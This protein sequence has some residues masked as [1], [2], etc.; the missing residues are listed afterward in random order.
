M[1]ENDAWNRAFISIEE[2]STWQSQL[3]AKIT[4]K[5]AKN[6][7]NI[8]NKLDEKNENHHINKKVAKIATKSE[9][10]IDNNEFDCKGSKFYTDVELNSKFC[11]R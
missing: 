9:Q 11:I 1:T 8:A 10:D 4:Y 5:S 7:S 3:K 6:K 2:I